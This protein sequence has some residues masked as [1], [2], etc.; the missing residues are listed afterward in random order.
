MPECALAASPPEPS[1]PEAWL[2]DARGAHAQPSQAYADQFTAAM[3]DSLEVARQ[4]ESPPPGTLFLLPPRP[5][6]P[7]SDAQV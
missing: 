2:A 7:G 3:N 5:R 6:L 4:G 1:L